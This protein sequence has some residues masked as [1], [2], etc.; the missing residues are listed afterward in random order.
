[1]RTFSLFTSAALLACVAQQVHLSDGKDTGSDRAAKREEDQAEAIEFRRSL[2][3]E[4]EDLVDWTNKVLYATNRAVHLF[5]KQS[6]HPSVLS[7]AAIDEIP[8]SFQQ[9][10]IDYVDK[11]LSGNFEYKTEANQ[12]LSNN[13]RIGQDWTTAFDDKTDGIRNVVEFDLGLNG[14]VENLEGAEYTTNHEEYW[15]HA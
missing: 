7:V 9:A 12:Y 2:G 6:C 13:P 3:D 4:Y 15:N 14:I 8:G 10:A 11:Y 5:T 1:M